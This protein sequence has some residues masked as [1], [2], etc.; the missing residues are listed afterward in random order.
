MFGSV[1]PRTEVRYSCFPAELVVEVIVT[2]VRLGNKNGA[3]TSWLGDGHFSAGW[4]MGTELLE[5]TSRDQGASLAG[6]TLARPGQVC[7]GEVK[8]PQIN[9]RS[10]KSQAACVIWSP[11]LLLSPHLLWELNASGELAPL[12]VASSSAGLFIIAYF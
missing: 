2:A 6:A 12:A 11:G 3:E 9:P 8:T 7:S 5:E 10:E 1:G 4:W